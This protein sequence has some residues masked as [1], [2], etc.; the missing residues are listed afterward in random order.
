MSA[1]ENITKDIVT[2]LKN[3]SNPAPILVTREFF[4]FDKLAITQFPAILVISGNEEREDITMSERRGTMDIELRCFVRGAQID[5]ARNLLIENIE[6]ALED[7]RDRNTTIDNTGVHYVQSTI[8]SIE[9][10]ERIAPIGQF[11]AVLSVTYA[12]KRGNP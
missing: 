4:E 2:Q 7:N 12:Y 8:N 10:I 3:M 11:N 5:T 6:Q 1:R 9:V